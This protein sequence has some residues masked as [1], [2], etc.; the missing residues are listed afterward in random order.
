MVSSRVRVREIQTPLRAR[1][2]ADP[3]AGKHIL[4]A[5]SAPSDLADPLHC[6]V[7]AAG[8]IV[9][10]GAH[11]AVGGSGDAP[12]SGDLLLAALAACQETTLRMA[13]NMG[14][15]LHSV[16]VDVEAD[17]DA[18]GTLA[19]GAPVGITAIRC[20]TTVVVESDERGDRAERLLRSAEKYCVI[21]DTLRSGVPVESTFDLS[22]RAAESAPQPES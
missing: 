6:S 10:A 13:A 2:Q 7:A 22:S 4:R 15:G 14:I 16:R 8:Q 9:S 21:L 11:P 17:W 20:R 5:T 18:R 1:Y 12:C 3:S 19:M